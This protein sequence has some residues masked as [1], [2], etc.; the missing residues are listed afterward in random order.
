MADLEHYD[1]VDRAREKQRSRDDDA[2]RLAAGD[3]SRDQ[4]QRENSW[5]RDF[6]APAAVIRRVKRSG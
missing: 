4:L 3:V 1:P 2:R 6:D 5:V